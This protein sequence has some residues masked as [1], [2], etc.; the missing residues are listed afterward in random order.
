[1]ADS[2]DANASTQGTFRVSPDEATKLHKRYTPLNAEDLSELAK[3]D[4]AI[5]VNSTGGIA[6][7]ATIHTP[8]PPAMTPYWSSII[9]HTRKTYARPRREV[10]AEIAARHKKPESRKKATIGEYEAD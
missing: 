6:P 8:P 4:M 1:V 10:E 9:N 5:R 7:T 2:I 3:Y